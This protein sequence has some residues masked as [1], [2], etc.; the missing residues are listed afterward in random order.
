MP[1]AA[2]NAAAIKTFNGA[3]NKLSLFNKVTIK[4]KIMA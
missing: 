2:I 3:E 1:P 4:I